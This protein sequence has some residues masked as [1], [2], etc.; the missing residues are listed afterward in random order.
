MSIQSNN[1]PQVSMV[2]LQLDE[3]PIVEKK[4]ILKDTLE[5]M[6]QFQIGIACVADKENKFLGL[7][8]DGDIRR[9]LLNI[10]KPLSALFMED[11]NDHMI[12]N[13]FTIYPSMKISEAVLFMKEKKIWDLPIVD[14]NK[15]LVGLFH[16]HPAIDYL[17]S[18]SKNK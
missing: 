9:M 3:F 10:Q 16:L 13:P 6:S 17:I 8:T 14:V 7:I 12:K 11:I 1:D 15:N 4:C 2:M 5:E 18:L